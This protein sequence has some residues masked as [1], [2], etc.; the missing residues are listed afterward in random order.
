MT[1]FIHLQRCCDLAECR[2][3]W[4]CS[5]ARLH[6]AWIPMLLSKVEEMT[7]EMLCALALCI[8]RFAPLIPPC[9]VGFKMMALRV[10]ISQM[11]SFRRERLS[12]TAMGKGRVC[13]RIGSWSGSSMY[14]I[15]LWSVLMAFQK[16]KAS[17]L[18]HARLASRRI[19]ACFGS[20]RFNKKSMS[21]LRDARPTLIL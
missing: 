1:F 17:G 5:A 9:R 15:W 14:S 20:D 4:G 11:L 13:N 18:D 2:V 3:V 12:S 10:G 6:S 7:A 16:A 8:Q 19:V 21:S